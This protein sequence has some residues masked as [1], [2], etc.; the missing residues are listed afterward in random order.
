MNIKD[1]GKVKVSTGNL[2]KI[3]ELICTSNN[4]EKPF[5]VIGVTAMGTEVA[6]SSVL[7]HQN[8]GTV[9]V[10]GK[11]TPLKISVS[12]KKEYAEIIAGIKTIDKHTTHKYMDIDFFKELRWDKN[13]IK[14]TNYFK[15][16]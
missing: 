5:Q 12:V 14:N 16:N 9:I 6:I 8:T 10:T 11:N 3:T 2:K 1:K 13:I 4:L 7:K 15:S